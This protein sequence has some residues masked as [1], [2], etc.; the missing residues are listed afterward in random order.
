M[1]QAK[2]NEYIINVN[3]EK[4]CDQIVTHSCFY[5]ATQATWRKI[6]I[7][8]WTAFYKE[9][10]DMRM[11]CG[12]VDGLAF[13]ADQFYQCRNCAKWVIST[14]VFFY[15]TYVSGPY[16]MILKAEKHHKNV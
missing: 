11:F 13:F 16:R 1:F 7:L 2:T 5:H 15:E 8:E 4:S 12:M 9:W 6:Q 3:S 10:D 14:I